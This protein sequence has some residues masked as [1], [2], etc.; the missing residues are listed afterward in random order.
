ML[1]VSCGGNNSSITKKEHSSY[2]VLTWK[3]YDY[4]SGD[5]PE[6]AIFILSGKELGKGKKGIDI[7]I[8]HLRELP[9]GTTI[10]VFPREFDPNDEVPAFGVN[11]M[12]FYPFTVESPR[13]YEVC[14]PKGI[15]FN[16]KDPIPDRG[17]KN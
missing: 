6:N 8:E 10:Y 3:D 9:N 15:I 4:D 17:T 2:R 16:Y 13:I 7:L 12:L 14:K 5:N 1:L 11:R